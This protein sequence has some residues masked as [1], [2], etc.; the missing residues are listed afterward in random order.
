MLVHLKH[1]FVIGGA[2]V[3]LVIFFCF[4]TTAR[5][6]PTF[7]NNKLLERNAHLT[8]LIAQRPHAHPV[9]D[10]CQA[11][12]GIAYLNDMEVLTNREKILQ[13]TG[14]DS[15]E[16]RRL[17]TQRIQQRSSELHLNGGDLRNATH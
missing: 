17:L 8:K 10:L 12:T 13:T 2:S 14:L 3:L 9:L 15:N 7:S 16:M 4:V 1:P 5:S 11:V 6:K